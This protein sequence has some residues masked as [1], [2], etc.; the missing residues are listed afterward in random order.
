MLKRELKIFLLVGGCTAL[1][2]YVVYS[3]LIN[4]FDAEYFYAKAIGFLSG[5]LFAYFANS[6]WTFRSNR[7]KG[8]MAM[9]L[10]LYISTLVLNVAV[11]SAVLKIGGESVIVV[12][13]AF[14]IATAVSA[15]S[16]FLGMKYV[17][18]KQANEKYL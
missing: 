2:D 11:N 5:T 14:L 15:A 10:L 18:F 6:I 13:I 17:V 8:N 12:Q 4:L 9:F 3:L 7:N 16:N 1:V